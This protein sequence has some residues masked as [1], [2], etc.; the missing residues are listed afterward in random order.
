M[1]LAAMP[2]WLGNPWALLLLPL[3]FTAPGLWAPFLAARRF[4][5]DAT[6]V[7]AIAVGVTVSIIGAAA[8]LAYTLHLPLAFVTAVMVAS[9]IASLGVVAVDTWRRG[10]PRLD[11][12]WAGLVVT[13]VAAL[14]SLPEAQQLA[15][16]SDPFYHL[17]AVRSLLRTGAPVVTDPFFGR[18][19]PPD[20]TSGALHTAL[21]CVSQITHIDPL[22]L[23]P[24]FTAL[25]AFIVVA[26]IW[27][28]ARQ[29]SGSQIV[30]VIATVAYIAAAD[31]FDFRLAGLPNRLSWGLAIIALILATRTFGAR[32]DPWPPALLATGV[33]YGVLVSHLGSAELLVAG[34]RMVLAAGSAV[35]AVRVHRR[36]KRLGRKYRPDPL[37]GTWWDVGRVALAGT[38]AI[39]LAIPGL[40]P[41]LLL[42]HDGTSLGGKAPFV[43]VT[44]PPG[45]LVGGPVNVL[46]PEFLPGGLVASVLALAVLVYV[47]V[48]LGEGPDEH[49][50]TSL[51]LGLLPFAILLNPLTMSIADRVSPYM[52]W[53]F[54]GLLGFAV[55]A[56]LAYGLSLGFR[57]KTTRWATVAAAAGVGIAVALAV[58]AIEAPWARDPHSM[59]TFAFSERYDVRAV[60][61]AGAQSRLQKVLSGT[62]IV[63]GAPVTL[64]QLAGVV[65]IRPVSVP[66]GNLPV[67]FQTPAD[68]VLNGD[69]NALVDPRAPE[70]VRRTIVRLLGA[71]FVVIDAFQVGV[72][73]VAL[74]QIEADPAFRSVYDSRGLH[75]FSVL[76]GIH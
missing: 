12:G 50:F 29:A 70:S 67:A 33:A 75:V 57:K 27:T 71:R 73:Q 21:A 13:T 66:K 69:M 1:T 16:A 28:L 63:A 61:G 14:I 34:W 43:N 30:G 10:F 26:A 49:A 65:S 47:F 2:F 36:R 39:G 9:G 7:I 48:R 22:A 74:G 58:P 56:P 4:S 24:A 19:A 11:A 31:S 64:Y 23:W 8:G 46:N 51:G 25:G 15:T 72:T 60:W 54:V 68:A 62:P 59:S 37:A 42:I 76:P 32:R 6:G 52:T 20:P 18:V 3:L 38:S 44:P 35:I 17:A 40:V 5:L 55:W 45:W 53:R 41:K